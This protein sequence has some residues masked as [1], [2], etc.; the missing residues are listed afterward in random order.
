MG[1]TNVYRMKGANSVWESRSHITVISGWIR[2][3]VRRDVNKGDKT[4]LA[5][6]HRAGIVECVLISMHC[7]L[8]KRARSTLLTGGTGFSHLH[9]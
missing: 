4:R 8:E 3:V 2:S 9:E 5:K 7:A 6:T 1:N